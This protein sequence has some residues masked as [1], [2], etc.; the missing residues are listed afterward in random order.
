MQTFECTAIVTRLNAIGARI[1]SF[2]PTPS[3]EQMP[4]LLNLR[5]EFERLTVALHDHPEV[6]SV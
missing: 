4:E 1:Q 6:G 3:H 5:Y 2:M